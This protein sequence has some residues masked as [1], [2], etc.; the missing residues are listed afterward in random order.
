MQTLKERLVFLLKKQEITWAKFSEEVGLS[1][2]FIST[3]TEN[4]TAKTLKKIETAYPN[5][6]INWL[7]TGDGDMLKS[8]N[9]G[10]TTAGDY[11]PISGD[12]NINECRSE[13]EKSKVEISYLKEQVKERDAQI[14]ELKVL[15]EKRLQ[16]KE[17]IINLL[18]TNNHG[19][20][21]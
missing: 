21:S 5:F 11:S 18:K 19:N 10:H 8:N 4:L 7:L 16:D 3:V 12:I 14:E 9:V 6:N 15:F 20:R 17:E 1:R 13:L 2:G